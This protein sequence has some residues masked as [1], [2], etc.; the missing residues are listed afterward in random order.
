MGHYGYYGFAP[1]VS[2]AERKR[3][4]QREV[5]KLRRQGMT[6][7]PVA[8][9]GRKIATTFWGK[10]WCDSLESYMDYANRLPRGRTYVR[11]GS[12]V[13]LAIKPGVIEALVSGS[14]VYQVRISISAAQRARWQSL[15]AECAGSIGS[16]VELLQGRFSDHVM[17]VITRRQ[18]G[19]F[20]SPGEIHLNCSCPDSATMCKHV[21]AV[22]YGVGARLDTQPELLFMLR[23]VDHEELITHAADVSQLGVTTASEAELAESDLGSVFGI[24]IE[25]GSGDE[26][27]ILHEGPAAAPP[28]SALPTPG[29]QD[30]RRAKKTA[31]A[32]TPRIVASAKVA[33]ATGRQ[34]NTASAPSKGAAR[35]GNPRKGGARVA[36]VRRAGPGKC[37]KP[38]PGVPVLGG[39]TSNPA[40]S[41]VP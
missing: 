17:G 15:C 36:S 25:Q 32:S 10:A 5:D 26:A 11:N 14:S 22:L 2:A 31:T 21:A 6:I 27:G 33:K 7:V 13:H 19:L 23:S 29:K 12:V 20:P 18:T 39:L 28:S 3:N 40:S 30:K 16:V 9:Q 4:A 41:S 8:I 37:D 34:T 1:Y 35:K 38:I 24:D